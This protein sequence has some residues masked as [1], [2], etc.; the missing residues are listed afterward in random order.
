MVKLLL[1]FGYRVD[2]EKGNCNKLINL[3]DGLLAILY[4]IISSIMLFTSELSVLII[5]LSFFVLIRPIIKNMIEY[6]K[7][8]KKP[9][10]KTAI[11][12]TNAT[13]VHIIKISVELIVLI[14]MC[15]NFILHG[16]FSIIFLYF[17]PFIVL[18]L[19]LFEDL[20]LVVERL[21]DAHKE[22][23]E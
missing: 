20:Q 10:D 18:L 15:I 3:V 22:I 1:K 21:Y 19:N 9:P 6:D 12:H 4:C 8:V 16:F 17:F 2:N 5:L 11:K 23:Y 13:K 7:M 14:L